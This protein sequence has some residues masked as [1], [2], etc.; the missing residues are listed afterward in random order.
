MPAQFPVNAGLGAM[1]WA[2]LTVWGVV[3]AV[4]VLQGLGFLS[5]LASGRM[6]LNHALGYIIL[7]LGLPAAV[8]LV[9]F[10]RARAASLQWLGAAV[11]LVFL[12]LMLIVDYVS[13]VEFRSP[14]RVAVLAP[15]L[16]LFFGAILLMGLPMFSLNRPL[17]LVTVATTLF[18]LTSMGL[19]MRAGHA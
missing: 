6:A 8:A 18:L 7:A 17:W 4:N 14:V 13:P 3:N 1:P 16:A 2:V 15:Y 11:F 12:V 19:A 5:R 9:A 10:L